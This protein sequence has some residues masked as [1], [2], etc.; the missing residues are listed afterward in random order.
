MTR[1]ELI[2]KFTILMKQ[3]LAFAGMV[4][5][6]DEYTVLDSEVF[7]LDDED[8]QRGLLLVIAGTPS[9]MIDEYFTNKISYTKDENM[10]IYRTIIKRA[11]LGIQAKESPYGLIYL[12][13]SFIDLS[14][15]ELNKIESFL[16]DVED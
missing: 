8:F 4:I 3:T 7:D 2:E 13:P 15:E 14:K 9:N 6:A 12:L 10:R 11:V 1:E 5:Q 16:N